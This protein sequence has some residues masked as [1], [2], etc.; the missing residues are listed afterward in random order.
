[1]IS[2]LAVFQGGVEL[3][4]ALSKPYSGYDAANTQKKISHFL[5]SGTRPMNCQTIAEKGFKCP[6]LENGECTCKAPAALCYKLISVDG[7]RAL[8][9][10]LP[11]ADNIIDN[12]KTAN[13]FV[14][15]YLYNQNNVLTETIINTVLLAQQTS[16]IVTRH[17]VK[18]AVLNHFHRR[19][20]YHR[21]LHQ[22]LR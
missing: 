15:E 20:L 18:N 9:S 3:I 19:C 13:D 22:I 11:V 12:M 17:I 6:K 4:H 21:L 8:I 10:A 14:E 5:G 7:L 1:M 16:L 2:N